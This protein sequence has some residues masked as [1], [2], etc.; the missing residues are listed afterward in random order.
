MT[1]LRKKITQ[2]A[3]LINTLLLAFLVMALALQALIV[4][5]WIYSFIPIKPSP[6]FETIFL[7]QQALVFPKRDML[8]FHFF[9]GIACVLMAAG[10]I[11]LKKQLSRPSM[12]SQLLALTLAEYGWTFLL[13]FSIFKMFVYGMEPWTKN[14][15]YISLIFSALSKIF[16]KEIVRFYAW[17]MKYF[18]E[19]GGNAR[20]HRYW[21]LFFAL[22]IFLVIYIPD[23][24]GLL[25]RMFMTDHFYHFDLIIMSPAWAHLKGAVLDIDQFTFYAIGLP[26][27][28]SW[29]AQIAGGF[30]YYSVAMVLCVGTVIYY[31]GVYALARFW[32]KSIPVAMAMVL[33]LIKWQMFH[34]GVSPIIFNYPSATIWRYPLDIVFLFLLLSH[35]RR[36]DWR[37]LAAA[38]IVCGFS[39]FYM[40]DTGV[41]MSIAFA[42]YL[43]GDLVMGIQEGPLTDVRRKVLSAAGMLLIAPMTALGFLWI[44]QGQYLFTAVFWKNLSELPGF[45]LMGYSDLPIYKSLLDGK[46]LESWMGFFIPFVYTLALVVTSTLFLLRKVSRE[47]LFIATLAVYGLGLY[48][49]YI[50]R[51]ADT[52]Y[53][54]VVLPFVFI[55]GFLLNRIIGRDNARRNPLLGAVLAGAAF[56]LFT[57]HYFLNYPNLLNLSRNPATHPVTVMKLDDGLSYFNHNDM[58]W[59]AQLKLSA[60]SLGESNE[61]LKTEKDF[62]DDGQLKDYFSQEFDFS[63]DADLID[64]LTGKEERVALIS[65]FETKILIQADRR[66]LFYYFPLTYSR[67]MHMRMFDMTALW[68]TGRL[69]KTMQQLQEGAPT[70]IFMEKILLAQSVPQYY[71]YLYP[72]LL[73]ILNYIH[74]NYVPY[75]QGH[76]LIAM[77]RNDHVAKF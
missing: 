67:P 54:V 4:T 17:A 35:L 28:I 77:K 68:T 30:S 10:M 12:A 51:S 59:T 39:S 42:F 73:V 70:Y 46:Y 27:V 74:Q 2:D 76:Y 34:P 61:D 64:R 9:I 22:L 47:H 44:A 25:A 38:A 72:D 31:I 21:D 41:Y 37:L 55:S 26:I 66:P 18:Q 13:V 60:N 8:F 53:Y 20:I 36:P 58:A 50:C 11:I 62:A 1:D 3:F 71:E 57:N 75:D 40:I 19:H 56:A 32:L 33:L 16:W 15:F 69:N 43:L 48:H 23:I 65:S 52:S 24:R 29:L 5:V 49:Y 7:R 63:R 14:I 6:L 45:F